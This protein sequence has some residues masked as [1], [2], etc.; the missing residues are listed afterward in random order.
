M[1]AGVM[2]AGDG[3]LVI[4]VGNVVGYGLCH[5]VPGFADLSLTLLMFV[6]IRCQDHAMATH[7]RAKSIYG[8]T[9]SGN[10]RLYYRDYLYMPKGDLP[11]SSR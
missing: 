2:R 8:V 10:K 9:Y 1:S 7:N 4:V 5:W 6:Q 11:Y 3:I